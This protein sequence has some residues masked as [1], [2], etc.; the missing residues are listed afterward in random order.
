MLIAAVYGI[1][2]EALSM[3][4]ERKKLR[5]IP[6]IPQYA[7]E[8]RKK[9]EKLVEI[10]GPKKAKKYF[11]DEVDI[12]DT[13]GAGTYY[14]ALVMSLTIALAIAK[15]QKKWSIFLRYKRNRQV[16]FSK[17]S[18]L[19][20]KE[21][22]FYIPKLPDDVFDMTVNYIYEQTYIF[23][24]KKGK[25][26]RG[27]GGNPMSPLLRFKKFIQIYENSC[28]ILGVRV[29][30]MAL[31]WSYFYSIYKYGRMFY[32]ETYKKLVEKAGFVYEDLGTPY[33]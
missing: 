26:V 30:H 13:D 24:D 2:A 31:T 32:K 25:V 7:Q 29:R 21:K 6:I 9:L 28:R 4:R 23:K 19:L 12:R 1:E 14:W 11:D 15:Q 33:Y 16:H 17:F 20:D 22:I 5:E 3:L 27:K 18:Q 10:T 8:F